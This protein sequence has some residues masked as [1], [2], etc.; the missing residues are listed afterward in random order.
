LTTPFDGDGCGIL[1]SARG[2]PFDLDELQVCQATFEHQPA[3]TVVITGVRTDGT[4]MQSQVAFTG[5]QP[6]ARLEPRP[7]ALGWKQMAEVRLSAPKPFGLTTLTTGGKKTDFDSMV[8]KQI[9][10]QRNDLRR[11][12]EHFPF[13]PNVH[14]MILVTGHGGGRWYNFWRHGD[15]WAQEDYRQVLVKDNLSPLHIYH[16][17][18][19]HVHSA[20][21]ASF[22]NAR[23]VSVYGIKHEHQTCFLDVVGGDRIRIFGSG[24]MSDAAPGSAHFRFRD[25]PNFL[26]S[27]LADEIHLN[28]QDKNA[29]SPR[30]PL[31]QNDPSRYAGIQDV[32]GGK[33]LTDRQEDEKR[34]ARP[35]L[36]RR[37]QPEE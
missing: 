21:Q 26:V 9:S 27:N 14:P 12:F 5:S 4:K 2:Q 17:H 15:I 23:D 3:F 35:I 37:G 8:T 19:Q 7:V 18:L 33:T 28:R 31:V 13:S 34:I 22:V 29:H 10:L 32:T 24:G 16:W 1:L 20:A 25:T 11:G 6:L 30:N 36:W